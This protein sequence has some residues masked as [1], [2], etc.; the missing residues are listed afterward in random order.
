MKLPNTIIS[1]I[2]NEIEEIEWIKLYFLFI[3]EIEWKINHHLNNIKDRDQAVEECQNKNIFTI[4]KNKN[5]KLNWGCTLYR[6]CIGGNLKLIN[7]VIERGANTWN[8][9]LYGAC[10]GGYLDI[11][12]LMIEKG[13]N[14][15]N[16]GLSG[17][18]IGG[19]LNIVN[20]MIEKGAY[21]WNWGLQAAC[22]GNNLNIVN[23]M[24]ELGA[25]Y[26]FYCERFK[27]DHLI[28]NSN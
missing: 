15:W 23:Y 14:D 21:D 22:R 28:K 9:G 6:T 25:D 12:K 20:L 19:H 10:H 4:Y 8:E 7:L 27:K 2:F 16:S 24:I 11:I 3:Y 17:A 18:C 26:C 13:A 5:N 1:L